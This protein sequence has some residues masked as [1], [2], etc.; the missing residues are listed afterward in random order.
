MGIQGEPAPPAHVYVTNQPYHLAL[1]ETRLPRACLSVGFKIP[2]FGHDTK[3]PSYTEAYK[4]RIKYA[5][6]NDVQKAMISYSIPITFDGEI[7]QFAYGEAERRFT[8]GE[9]LDVAEGVT[10]TLQS[11]IV[12]EPE[13][14]AY[15][16]G[17]TLEQTLGNAT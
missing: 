3:F 16:L 6:L 7:P 4:A 15:L 13:Q 5:A 14:K 2:D 9:R 8:I 10:M 12:M 17:V 1:N 11:G